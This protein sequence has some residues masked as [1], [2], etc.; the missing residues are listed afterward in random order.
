[1]SLIIIGLMLGL[2]G[3]AP[4]YAYVIGFTFILGLAIAPVE[5]TM[6]TLMQQSTPDHS[7]GRV[8]SASGAFGSLAGIVSMAV[9][10][11]AAEL[12]GIPAVYLVCGTLMVLAGLLFGTLVREPAPA[13]SQASS[14]V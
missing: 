4:N 12:V 1:V 13:A 6:T 10:G 11:G 3:V 7:R 14:I 5:A 9:A 2:I 8:S